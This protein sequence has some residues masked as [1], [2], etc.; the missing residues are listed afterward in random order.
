LVLA[1]NTIDDI[2]ISASAKENLETI[3]SKIRSERKKR[4]EVE[5]ELRFIQDGNTGAF[6]PDDIV[7]LGSGSKEFNMR[8][9]NLWKNKI[10]WNSYE[11]LTL[12]LHLSS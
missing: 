12:K 3:K 9:S 6:R 2:P 1:A 7:I 4:Q 10:E 5:R 11:N 8:S